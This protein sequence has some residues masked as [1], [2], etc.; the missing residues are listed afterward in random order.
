MATQETENVGTTEIEAAG[1][2]ELAENEAAL[3]ASALGAVRREDLVLPVL[4]VTQALS[5]AVQRG[6]AEQG[7]FLNSLT[8]ED[9][10]SET[11]L[12]VVAYFLGRFYND[13]ETGR[14]YVAAGDTA[15]STWPEKYAGLKFTDIPDAEESYKVWANQPG[16]EWGRGPAISTTHNFVGFRPDEPEVPLRLSL[17]RTSAP[18]GRKLL[19]LLQF[20]P[21]PWAVTYELSLSQQ[22][23]K[24]QRPFYVVNVARG[25]QTTAEERQNAVTMSRAVQESSVK[26]AGDEGLDEK[27]ATSAAPEGALEV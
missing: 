2:T 15:P 24:Q 20:A 4:Q 21:T 8:G 17:M 13:K 6:D 3:A 7:H 10:G 19:T 22:T 25:R 16:N 23:D 27:P 11:E 1:S 26:F 14:T 18:A 5:K 12:V 9:Y